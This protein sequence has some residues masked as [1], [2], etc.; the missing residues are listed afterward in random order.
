MSR[1]HVLGAG[2]VEHVTAQH[3]DTPQTGP[4]TM[5]AATSMAFFF[6]AQTRLMSLALKGALPVEYWSIFNE[7][8]P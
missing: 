6:G 7:T 4:G 1:G 3:V 8:V 2:A 5:S